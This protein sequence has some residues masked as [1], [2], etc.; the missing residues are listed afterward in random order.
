MVYRPFTEDLAGNSPLTLDW[1]PLVLV[2]LAALMHAGW[3]TIAKLGDD[4]LVA[5]ALIKVPNVLVAAAVLAFVELPAI[6]CWPY[7]LGSTAASCIYFYCLINAYR[8]G[9]LSVAYPVSRS[10]APLLVM[11]LSMVAVGEIPT[12]AGFAGVVVISLA[13]LVIGL[14]R[15]ATRQHYQTLLW[16]AGVGIMIATYTVLDGMGARISGSA[17]GYVAVLN[18]CTG[19]LL[20]AAAVRT[21]GL[22]VIET[23]LRRHWLRSLV[24]GTMM[25]ATYSIVVYALTIAPMALVAA[26]RESSVIFAALI[27]T[28]LLH[29]PFGLKRVGASIAVAA[30]IAILAI[31]G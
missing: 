5:M 6:E 23:A 20:C 7:L 28:V 25:L 26:L 2:L 15:G 1:L 3:N 4:G 13:I 27:G 18:I 12:P 14:Q 22:A 9:D 29:E 11:G 21:R 10:I 19:V 24:G 16:A 30:G 8:V 17:V 31:W